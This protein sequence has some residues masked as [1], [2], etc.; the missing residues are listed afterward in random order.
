MITFRQG[1]PED[2][3]DV[4]D[5]LVMC[6]MS[7][8]VDAC[9]CL[10][11]EMEDK[12][13]GLGRLEEAEGIAYLRPIAVSPHY[14]GQGIGHQLM[15]ELL[16]GRDE[17]RVVARGEAAHFYSAL[18]LRPMDWDSVYAD[19]REECIHCSEHEQCRPIALR[20]QAGMDG[21]RKTE[22]R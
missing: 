19:Y 14:Q 20:Y 5:L 8:E 6:G 2:N 11:A 15:Q 13:V 22:D 3:A 18:G 12:L 17:V 10:L 1:R 7:A 4:Q 9:E 21:G 16:A